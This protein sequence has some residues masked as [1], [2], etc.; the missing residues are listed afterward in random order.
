MK[1]RRQPGRSDS[2]ASLDARAAARLSLKIPPPVYL[3]VGV[4]LIYAV[5]RQTRSSPRPA[6][7]WLGLLPLAA[8]LGLEAQALGLFKRKGTTINPLRPDKSAR[9]VVEGPY[10]FTRNPMY[11]GMALLLS[12]WSLI[13][14]SLSGVLVVPAFIWTLTQVQIIPEEKQLARK[15]GEPYQTYLKQVRRW[16]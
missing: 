7:R 13:R 1:H 11:L 6:W 15:F 5:S 3:L 4:G 2:G 9:L 16:L 12:G 14:S 8:G 10:R